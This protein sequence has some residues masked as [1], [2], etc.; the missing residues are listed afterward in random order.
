MATQEGTSSRTVDP[1][2][3]FLEAPNSSSPQV[4]NSR[5]SS[6]VAGEEAAPSPPLTSGTKASGSF[7]GQLVLGAG[8]G[9]SRSVEVR[10][11]CA[12]RQVKVTLEDSLQSHHSAGLLGLN[13]EFP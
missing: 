6:G 5:A 12:G 11:A 3:S 13:F 4:R 2:A 1:Q 7:Q 10:L 9:Q 8:G